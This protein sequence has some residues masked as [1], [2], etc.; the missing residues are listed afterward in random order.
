MTNEKT[1]KVLKT[2][3]V[4][5]RILGYRPV[6]GEGEDRWS[7]R[8]AQKSHVIVAILAAAVGGLVALTV[9]KAIPKMMSQLMSEMMGAMMAHME[10][11]GCSPAEI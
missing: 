8:G 2:F 1:L 4:C 11:A 6:S 9:T 10:E 7:Q 5:N 3:R